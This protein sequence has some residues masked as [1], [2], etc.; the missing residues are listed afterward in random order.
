MKIRILDIFKENEATCIL[1]RTTLRDYLEN[2]PDDFREFFIQRGIV[3]NRFLDNIADTLINRLHIPTMVL[4]DGS[5]VPAVKVGDDFDLK[6]PFRVLDG[7]QRTH[8]LRELREAAQFIDKHLEDDISITPARIARKVSAELKA[9]EISSAAF[10]KMLSYYRDGNRLDSLFE[11]NNVWLEIWLSLNEAQQIQKMLILNAGHKSVNIKHQIELL[12]WSDFADFQNA[13]APARIVREKQK[14]STVY[15]K[16]RE[17]GEF[18]FSHI[19]GAFVSL[20]EG[21][22]VSTNADYSAAMSFEESNSAEDDLVRV[23]EKVLKEFANTLK[24]LDAQFTSREAVRWLGREVV[25]VGMFGA[26]GSHANRNDISC[27]NALASFT[28]DVED[29]LSFIN[30]TDFEVARDNVEL[31]KVNIGKINRDAVF[32]ATTAFL[33][34]ARDSFSDWPLLFRVRE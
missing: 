26:I 27:E 15:S 8:R 33:N 23:N 21:A 2:L 5:D 13:L 11:D 7:L 19:I 29:Y 16:S 6:S 14:S 24:S 34:G 4:I 3:T 17:Q 9:R 1:C 25:L 10:Q 20:T 18:H 31:S 12:F 28:S 32:K 30:L 22:T